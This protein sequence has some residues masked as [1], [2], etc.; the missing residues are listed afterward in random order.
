MVML[1]D[2][3]VFHY[4]QINVLPLPLVL[5]LPHK[6]KLAP[7]QVND[8]PLVQFFDMHLFLFLAAIWLI[9]LPVL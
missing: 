8:V 9:F 4:L 3:N 2:N 6:S 1:Q 7:A 5:P